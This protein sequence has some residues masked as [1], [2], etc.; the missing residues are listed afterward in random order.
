MKKVFI[1]VIFAAGFFTTLAFVPILTV[2]AGETDV[3]I[4]KLIQRGVLSES[5]GQELLNKASKSKGA[6]TTMEIPKWV[7]N[8][9]LKGD[10]R[11]RYQYEDTDNDGIDSRERYRIR[12]RFGAESKVN[13]QWKAG[14]GLASGGN[15]P[16]STN[17]TLE[18]TFQSPDARIDYAYAKFTPN[19]WASLIGGKFKNPIW[20]AKDLLWDGDIRPDGAA[21]HLKFKAAPAEIFVTPAYFILDEYKTDKDDPAMWLVQVG[22][23]VKIGK[24]MYF[25][26]AGTYYDFSNVTGNAFAHSAGTNS[27]DV[28]GD[29]TQDYDSLAA[30]GEFGVHLPGPVPLVA[31]FGQ[32]VK[33]DADD[34]SKGWL[35]GVKFGHKKVKGLGQWQVK[36]NYRRLEKDAWPDF[37]PDSDFYGGATDVKGSEVEFK[38]GLAKHVSFGVDYY[39]DVKPINGDTN[40]EQKVLQADLVIKW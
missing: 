25:K 34:D 29:L 35:V 39:F 21:A 15:D 14:F 33:S 32:Y 37:L 23:K 30:D 22:T 40:R 31:V 9:K 38:L 26:V 1:M 17:Q 20:G 16:R 4:K 27:V 2:H 12:W 7:K 6:E 10:F 13:D 24:V 36:Y 3:L 8:I 19:P 18:N 5:D 11:L 28:A